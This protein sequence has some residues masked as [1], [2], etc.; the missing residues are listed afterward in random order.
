MEIDINNWIQEDISDNEWGQEN[1]WLWSQDRITNL[2]NYPQLQEGTRLKHLHITPLKAKAAHSIGLLVR[3]MN[4]ASHLL[5]FEER[6]NKGPWANYYLYAYLLSCSAL[7]LLGRIYRGD[8]DLQVN[9]NTALSHGFEV[10]GLVSQNA[11]GELVLQTNEETYSLDHLVA[12][13]NLAA[14]GQGQASARRQVIR[15]LFLHIELLDHFGIRISQAIDVFYTSLCNP[16]E[17]TLR[18]QL[19]L[20]G[21]EPVLYVG[22]DRPGQAFIEPIPFTYK[23]ILEPGTS[24]S[25][26]I[27]NK[28][29]QVYKG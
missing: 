18:R 19:A 23:N 16:A 2:N 14:H 20:C 6:E 22:F 28:D 13:R 4:A 12:L 15:D 17:Q 7:E 26:Q 8:P 29:W 3:T 11:N 25:D 10:S 27:L 21:I 5:Y 24:P 1:L 9:S